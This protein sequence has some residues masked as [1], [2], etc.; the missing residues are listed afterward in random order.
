MKDHE[1]LELLNLYLDHEITAADV[2]RLE[3]EVQGNASRRNTYFEYC[4]MQR[5]CTLLAKDFADQPAEKKIITFEPRR[6]AWAGGSFAVGGLAVA[7][8]CVALVL[9]NRAPDAANVAVPP[10]HTSLAVVPSA[11]PARAAIVEAPPPVEPAVVEKLPA[12]QIARTVTVPGHHAELKPMFVAAP[13]GQVAT[14]PDAAAML[15]AV[16]QNAQAQLE[17]LKAEIGRA[18]CRERV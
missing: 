12:S 11:V 5:A 1:F 14:N 2:A 16:Q 3:A 13:L 7:A 15:A 8:A 4:R 9:V 10:A 17:W 6:S 18:S